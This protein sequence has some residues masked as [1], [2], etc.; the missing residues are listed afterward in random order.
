MIVKN[1]KKPIIIGIVIIELI[2][3]IA[4]WPIGVVR[5]DT[6]YSSGDT[7]DYVFTTPLYCG[8]EIT[9]SFNALGD[10]L[11]QHSFAVKRATELSDD[12]ILT[13]ALKT[14]QGEVLYSQSFTADEITE[15]GYRTVDLN[16]KLRVGEEYSY[17]ISVT[18]GEGGVGVTCTPYPED[19]AP[20]LISLTQNGEIL[21]LQSFNQYVYAQKL[22]IKNILFTWLFLWIIGAAV[23]E[24]I[25]FCYMHSED[26]CDS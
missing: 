2:A 20:S 3:M 7:H 26:K 19:Y 17:T 13:Y 1:R 18:S 21:G 4:V 11:K 16:V 10:T 12:W 25:S 15:S 23:C 9:Q 6:M 8:D 14:S 5:R 22:N 24:V